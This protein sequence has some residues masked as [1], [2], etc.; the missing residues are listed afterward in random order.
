MG[1]FILEDVD[2]GEALC[3]IRKGICTWP[4]RCQSFS[5]FA[6]AYERRVRRWTDNYL[7]INNLSLKGRICQLTSAIRLPCEG[8]PILLERRLQAE[9]KSELRGSTTS[10]IALIS[11]VAVLL[12]PDIAPT[13]GFDVTF[14]GYWECDDEA[15][16]VYAVDAIELLSL[17][18]MENFE[19]LLGPLV[20]KR[21]SMWSSNVTELF[22]GIADRVAVRTEVSK[23][24]GGLF[25]AFPTD[26]GSEIPSTVVSDV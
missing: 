12:W 8:V 17:P 5:I 15:A 1:S 25:S 18:P 20:A 4:S 2:V 24:L 22:S 11:P 26:N 14:D 21:P 10:D 9:F 7:D 3:R 13:R 23:G 19:G 6:A 16:S